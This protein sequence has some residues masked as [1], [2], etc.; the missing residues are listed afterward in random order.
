MKPTALFIIVLT[1]L[2]ALA[3]EDTSTTG[4]APAQATANPTSA[5]VAGVPPPPADFD[6]YPQA[7]A[8]YLT[9]HPDEG[10]GLAC[11]YELYDAWDMPYYSGER[12]CRAGNVDEDPPREVAVVLAV[13]VSRLEPTPTASSGNPSPTPHQPECGVIWYRIAVL[14]QSDTGFDVAYTSPH[15]GLSC[16]AANLL[17]NVILEMRDV[18]GNGGGELAY[19]TQWCGAH[20]CGVNVNIVSGS[21]NAYAP[22]TPT[23][24]DPS[25]SGY[26]MESPTRIEFTDDD[27]DGAH[28]LVL[29]GG[30]INSAASGP[31]RLRTETYAW[32][33]SQYALR[34]SVPGNE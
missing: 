2:C 9:A 30:A 16:Q 27:G 15:F 23:S 22:L 4:E 1:G 28:E 31:G 32:D 33:G 25:S 13:K 24:T 8:D 5:P 7:V 21:D 26:R 6:A 14:D 18:N 10:T 29:A 17:G 11:L 20:T 34:S 12:S 19:A 3:C